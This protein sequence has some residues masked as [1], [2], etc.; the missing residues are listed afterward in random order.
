MFKN[1]RFEIV[2]ISGY[3]F[4]FAGA[5]WRRIEYFAN[6]FSG[7]SINVY[8]IG[9]LLTSRNLVKIIKKAKRTVN[10][11]YKNLNLPLRIEHPHWFTEGFQLNRCYSRALGSVTVETSSIPHM[12][13]LLA[14]YIA[15]KLLKAK[16]V[17]DVRDHLE[18][19]LLWTKGFSQNFLVY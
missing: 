6:F 8:V 15:A 2:I 5:P 17:V 4:P 18:Y 12:E 10:D 13:Q 14:A 9:T 19:W 1:K 16:L 7:K 3:S 11:G